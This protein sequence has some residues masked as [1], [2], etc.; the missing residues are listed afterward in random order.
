MN[1][2]PA[3]PVVMSTM[4]GVEIRVDPVTRPLDRR[5]PSARRKYVER[6][7][8]PDSLTTLY[9]VAELRYV[10]VRSEM[11]SPANVF[12]S[13]VHVQTSSPVEHALRGLYGGRTVE[14]FG[15]VAMNSSNRILGHAIIGQGNAAACPV[16][17]PELVR[18]LCLSGAV[19]FIVF[20]NHPSGNLE[21][22]VEDMAF[23]QRIANVSHLIGIKLLDHL[24]LT[25]TG[26]LSMLDGGRGELLKPD[27]DLAR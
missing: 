24:L 27:A 16:S 13:K 26:Y 14:F 6:D 7:V 12:A 9:R 15:A 17:M 2:R 25:S 5:R 18:F 19:G 4:A 10:D 3:K 20:H 1:T 8:T 22:S 23:T 21:W 11:W